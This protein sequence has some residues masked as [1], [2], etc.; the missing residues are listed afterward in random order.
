MTSPDGGQRANAIKPQVGDTVYL[1]GDLKCTPMYLERT[2]KKGTT[3]YGLCT[4]TVYE[5]FDDELIGKEMEQEF[6]LSQLT[7]FTDAPRKG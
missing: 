1:R 2:Y 4:W 3:E 6:L 7:L 5:L